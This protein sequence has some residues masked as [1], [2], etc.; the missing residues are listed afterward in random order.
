MNGLTAAPPQNKFAALTMYVFFTSLALYPLLAQFAAPF[1]LASLGVVAANVL[2]KTL[3]GGLHVAQ[4]P[5]YKMV[6]TMVFVYIMWG[7]ISLLLGNDNTYI[8]L[9]SQGFLIYLLFPLLFVY[10]VAN[11]LER[12]FTNYLF[13]LCVVIATVSVLIIGGYFILV[14]EPESESL[15]LMNAFFKAYGLNWVIDHNSGFLGLY[16]FTGHLLLIAAG[17]SFYQYART[18]RIR[19]VF[20]VI[21]F[22]LG[23][24]ADGHR[25]LMVSFL[26]LVVMMLPLITRIIGVQKMMF[27]VGTIIL[28]GT[29][30]AFIGG[31]WIMARFSFTS[32]DPSTLERFL[33]IPALFDKI[34][35]RPFFGSGFGAVARVIRSVERPFSYEVDFL[36]TWMKLGLFGSV[37][38]FGTY[39]A[40]LN[41]A[42][43]SGGDFGYVLF[44]VGVAFFL[45]MG[46]NGGTAMSTDSAVFHLIMFL[47]IALTIRMRH[48]TALPTAMPMTPGQQAAVMAHG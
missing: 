45:Y 19:H 48:L 32:D 36:A 15:F 8:F 40:A 18:A 37:L 29:I 46:T 27:L 11:Q 5:M 9:D 14:G 47:L 28:I 44:S 23:I 30:G 6:W 34:A 26:L 38:Y 41:R 16:T 43:L 33:Q 42:R 13:K 20:M 39:L 4:T 25:A 3:F 10:I 1:I 35:E 31:D 7:F 2:L 12:Q 17:M 22:G 24:F 21:L